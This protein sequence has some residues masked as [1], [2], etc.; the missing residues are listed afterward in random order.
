MVCRAFALTFS[1]VV[2]AWFLGLAVGHR[3]AAVE[4]QRPVVRH[5]AD[6][7]ACRA[8][9]AQNPGGTLQLNV[10]G[11]AS[12]QY[13]VLNVGGNASLNGTLRLQA[14]GYVPTAGDLLK[15]VST[16]GVVS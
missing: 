7:R 6:D 3:V 5:I 2:P 8:A 12:G 1:D 15:L 13:D 10:A 16:G 14:I 9:I 4:R 11:P